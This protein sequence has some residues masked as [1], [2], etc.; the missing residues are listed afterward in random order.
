[1]TTVFQT[2]VYNICISVR[3]K[4]LHPVYAEKLNYRRDINVFQAWISLKSFNGQNIEIL[5]IE[6]IFKNYMPDFK[7]AEGTNDVN[8]FYNSVTCS[9]KYEIAVTFLIKT[10]GNM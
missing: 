1:M 3:A 4:K 8:L 9:Q 2:K 10:I 6:F 7:F 5:N